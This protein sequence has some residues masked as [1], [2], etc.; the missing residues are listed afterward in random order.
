VPGE[1][2]ALAL[3]AAQPGPELDAVPVQ[4]RDAAVSAP[5]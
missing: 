2:Q 4:G 1:V 3:A 5:S